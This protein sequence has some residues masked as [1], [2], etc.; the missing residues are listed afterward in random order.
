[1]TC[2]A[3]PPVDAAAAAADC[4]VAPG[5][6]GDSNSVGSQTDRL[7]IVFVSPHVKAL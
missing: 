6:P 3:A 1:M 2:A 5:R 4:Q 7:N